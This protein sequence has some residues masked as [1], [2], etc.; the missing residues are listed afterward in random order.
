[1]I[2]YPKFYRHQRRKLTE[3]E[4]VLNA[5]TSLRQDGRRGVV[6]LKPKWAVMMAQRV[7]D[8]SEELRVM[9]ED[10]QRRKEGK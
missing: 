10:W 7:D 6:A 4:C 3:T 2:I 8:L 1:M 5:I 9:R